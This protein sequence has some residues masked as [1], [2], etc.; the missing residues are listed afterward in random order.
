[1][2]DVILSGLAEILETPVTE[3]TVLGDGVPW[4]SLTVVCTIALLDEKAGV[5][6]DG[7]QLGDCVTVAD[8]LKLAGIE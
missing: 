3:A 1:M 6:V 2:K 5:L 8:V 4:D 7:R